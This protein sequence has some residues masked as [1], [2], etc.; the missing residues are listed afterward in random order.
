MSK[1]NQEIFKQFGESIV[2]ELKKVSKRFADS[3]EYK[4]TETSFI[5]SASPYI[6]TLI[7]GRPPTSSGAAKGTPTLQQ[8]IRVWIDEKGIAPRPV[9]GKTPTLESLSWAISKSIH[10]RGD[11]LYQKGGGNNIFDSIITEDRLNNLLNLIGQKY[12]N[13]INSINLHKS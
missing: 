10:M 3:I 4:A 8:I 1:N 11:L 7:D 6:R 5:I 12:F 9:N 2:P 13:E